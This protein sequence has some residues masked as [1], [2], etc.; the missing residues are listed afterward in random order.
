M[1]K[2]KLDRVFSEYIRLR[3]ADEKG[4]CRCISC[5]KI[6]HWK[7]MDCGH[8]INRKHM[9]L[10]F[11]DINCNAQ[12]RACNRFDEGNMEG[13]RMGLIKK[14]GQVIIEKLYAMKNE[15]CRISSI[16]Y[17]IAIKH[18]KKKV[19]KLKNEKV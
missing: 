6:A 14:H 16:E 2:E 17:S 3:D 9:A 7:D 15:V 8:F 11:N 5:G 13:Y 19:E 1:S 12:C 4:F 18:Y 10:R